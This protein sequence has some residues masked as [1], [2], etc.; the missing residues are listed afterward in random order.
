MLHSLVQIC[1]NRFTREEA[2]VHVRRWGATVRGTYGTSGII[3]RTKNM[4]RWSII[5][6]KS[7]GPELY[8]PALKQRNRPRHGLHIHFSPECVHQLLRAK[9]IIG[10]RRT[11]LAIIDITIAL[12]YIFD[13]YPTQL[14]VT[15]RLE[16]TKQTQI[17]DSKETNRKTPLCLH[18]SCKKIA[19]H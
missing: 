8:F 1:C 13:S 7:R 10:L 9:H 2:E 16:N 3:W 11:S 14:W 18:T 12:C 6:I 19:C 17:R 5:L 15:A 4:L